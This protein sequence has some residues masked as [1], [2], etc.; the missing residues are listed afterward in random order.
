MGQKAKKKTIRQSRSTRAG[1]TFPVSRCER[2]L[3]KRNPK[4][5]IGAGAAVYLAAVL[6]YMTAELLELSGN[7]SRDAEKR[8][9]LPR[10]LQLSIRNDEELSRLLAKTTIPSGWSAATRLSVSLPAVFLG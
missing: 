5:R 6:E 3:R 9:I 10:H 4:L 7:V 2:Y 8:R 1:L